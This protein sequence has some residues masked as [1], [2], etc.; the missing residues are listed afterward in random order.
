[1]MRYGNVYLLLRFKQLGSV[2]IVV[3]Y[4]GGYQAIDEIDNYVLM[5]RSRNW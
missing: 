5:N 1:M 2:W 4:G 3:A